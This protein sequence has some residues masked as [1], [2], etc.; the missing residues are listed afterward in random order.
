MVRFWLY[1]G[2]LCLLILVKNNKVFF[3]LRF[4]LSIIP[5]SSNIQINTH[6]QAILRNP[7]VRHA[8]LKFLSKRLTRTYVDAE[9]HDEDKVS[10]EEDYDV[11]QERSKPN[12]LNTNTTKMIGH[13]KNSPNSANNAAVKQLA[14]SPADDDSIMTTNTEDWNVVNDPAQ[15]N[16]FQLSEEEDK[17]FKQLGKLRFSGL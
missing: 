8:G 11:G 12:S 1:D 3:G 15:Q 17:F 6:I 10:D 9:E 5:C 16:N 7:K 2:V 14:Q 13:I 4:T